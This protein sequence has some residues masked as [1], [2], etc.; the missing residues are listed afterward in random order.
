MYKVTLDELYEM[1]SEYRESIWNQARAVGREP[2][3]YLHWSAGHYADGRES[4]MFLDEYHLCVDRDGS[5]YAEHPLDEVLSHTWRRNT[6]SVGITMSCAYNATTNDLGDEP[7]TAEQIESMAQAIWKIADGL[8]LTISKQYVLT[9]GEASANEDGCYL[10]PT[11]AP[12]DDECED[13]NVRWDLE[14]LGTEESPRYNPWATDGSR[15]GDV[16]RGKALYYKNTYGDK[17]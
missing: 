15:G 7:P 6:G 16:L 5:I 9:H 10:H 17:E 3:I 8:W 14:Y 1:A 4:Q 12:W 13:G 11:Y 2:R